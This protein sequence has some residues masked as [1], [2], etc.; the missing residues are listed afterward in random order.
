MLFLLSAAIAA[1][2]AAAT[3]KYQEFV[4]ALSPRSPIVP[5]VFSVGYA[6]TEDINVLATD[7]FPVLIKKYKLHDVRPE[8]H[9]KLGDV[10]S[11]VEAFLF[12]F[13]HGANAELR[14]DPAVFREVADLARTVPNKVFPGGN[15][16][17]IAHR[18]AKEEPKHTVK[19]GGQINAKFRDKLKRRGI[20]PICEQDLESRAMDTHL[21]IEYKTHDR[22]A[23]VTAPRM[24]RFYLNADKHNAELSPANALHK[25]LASTDVFVISGLQLVLSSEEPGLLAVSE[26]L[27][28]HHGGS[29]FESGSYED[30]SL[31]QSIWNKGIFTSTRS[32]G[33][34]EQELALLDHV[35]KT[36]NP[37]SAP[38]VT[39]S[40][41][42]ADW[43]LK[44]VLSVLS[45]ARK[46]TGEVRLSRIHMHALGFQVLCFDPAEW[47]HGRDAL[48]AA[49][50][51]A[52]ELACGDALKE[53]TW[54]S[55]RTLS[56]LP[57]K[58]IPG[59]G[60]RCGEKTFDEFQC[61]VAPVLV[62]KVPVRTA[63]IGDNISGAGLARQ[64][65]IG[66]TVLQDEL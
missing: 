54:D 26:A 66:K 48:A 34:N 23:G 35:I 3:E 14:V 40:S 47:S 15:A 58:M 65:Y 17:C 10:R 52:S 30:K 51:V 55:F 22:I 7:L 56:E 33:V 6:A 2:I 11:I 8:H 25:T 64:V 21:A 9:S 37:S 12:S 20:Q 29:H 39:E 38:E 1:A 57:M 42:D 18:I 44:T 45:G 4:R 49:S 43:A 41:P 59:A 36:G 50:L 53:H 62:C 31:F 13:E 27:A 46:L 32:L 61:C 63:G 60:L 19:L 5:Q 28:N 16:L 24:N